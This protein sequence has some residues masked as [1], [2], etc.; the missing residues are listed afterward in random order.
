MAFSK[1]VGIRISRYLNRS[2]GELF[3]DVWVADQIPKQR[4]WTTTLALAWGSQVCMKM[5]VVNPRPKQ[6]SCIASMLGRPPLA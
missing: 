4:V 2:A 5:Q 1:E 6:Y 3:L